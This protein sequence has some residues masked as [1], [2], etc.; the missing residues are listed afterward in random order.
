MSDTALEPQP[1][2]QQVITKPIKDIKVISLAEWK[3]N[4]C[5]DILQRLKTILGS[6]HLTIDEIT[7]QYSNLYE[8]KSKPSINRWLK[9]FEKK[10]LIQVSGR[11]KKPDQKASEK[12]YS[13][14]AYIHYVDNLYTTAWNDDKE[15]GLELA[16]RVIAPMQCKFDIGLKAD[17][18]YKLLSKY[19]LEK[20]QKSIEILQQIIHKSIKDND[21][22]SLELLDAIN[23]LHDDEVVVF[24]SNLRFI[25]WFL[26][27]KIENFSSGLKNAVSQKKTPIGEIKESK[28]N[29]SDILLEKDPEYIYLPNNFERPP[30]Y[31]TGFKN[32][33]DY[34]LDIRY[35]TILKLLQANDHALSIAELYRKFSSAFNILNNKYLCYTSSKETKDV[36]KLS[37]KVNKFITEAKE[38][39]IEINFDQ[40]ELL[41]ESTIYRLVQDLKEAGLVVEAG[42]RVKNNSPKDQLLY[43]SRGK[44]IIYFEDSDEFWLQEKTWKKASDLIQQILEVYFGKKLT[45]KKRFHEIFTEIEKSR[46][47]YFKNAFLDTKDPEVVKYFFTNLNNTELN[48][49]MDSLGTVHYFYNNDEILK[50]R[51]DLLGLFS[52]I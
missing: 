10:G 13:L 6:K 7:E 20:L 42:L 28:K 37:E 46:F 4:C 2:K 22:T 23:D 33:M 8:P 31:F 25:S 30:I 27:D 49:L 19:E 52:N 18:V 11:V 29:I 21:P 51:N 44:T 14:T 16:Q 40:L 39:S 3:D 43:T 34:M 41:S 5:D 32:Y 17:N 50:F 47:E 26:L 9:D 24:Y 48:A 15:R 38:K 45:D 1:V 35:G 36:D 12:L